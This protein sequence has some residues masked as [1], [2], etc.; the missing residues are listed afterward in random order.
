MKLKRIAV[1]PGFWGWDDLA[2]DWLLD[3]TQALQLLGEDGFFIVK[4][5]F[6]SHVLVMAASTSGKVLA[7]RGN[8]LWGWL[9]D[10]Q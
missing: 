4:L 3:A 9:Q 8:A 10:V 5:V 6:I 1:M 7:V 2:D